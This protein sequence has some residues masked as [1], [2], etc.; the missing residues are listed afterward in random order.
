MNFVTI[1]QTYL[2]YTSE[3]CAEWGQSGMESGPDV[4]MEDGFHLVLL[5]IV[6]DGR[7]LDHFHLLPRHNTICVVAGRLEVK[8]KQ[9]A[10]RRHGFRQ[11]VD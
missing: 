2:L 7:K 9:V 8:H 11:S 4:F 5:D 1:H 10:E 6:Q 3:V